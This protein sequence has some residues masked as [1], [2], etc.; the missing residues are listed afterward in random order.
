MLDAAGFYAD[1]RDSR[2]FLRSLAPG[3]RVLDLCCYTGAFALNAAAAG[4]QSAVG[5]D[6]SQPAVSLA[7]QNA[8]LNGVEDRCGTRSAW[9]CVTS[10]KCLCAL[11]AALRHEEP[12]VPSLLCDTIEHY[13]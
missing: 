7:E 2:L 12:R 10:L 11:G 9:L 4:A 1:Q 3:K 5:V 8:A 6:S 13:K